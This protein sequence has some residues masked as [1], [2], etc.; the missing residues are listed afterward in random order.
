MTVEILRRDLRKRQEKILLSQIPHQKEI[1]E[2]LIA[3]EEALGW[4]RYKE[5]KEFMLAE[6][7]LQEIV[8]IIDEIIL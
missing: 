4:N 1:I 2:L 5:L 8:K 6:G 7:R 3:L